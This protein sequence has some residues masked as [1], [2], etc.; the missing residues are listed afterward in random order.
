MAKGPPPPPVSLLIG[1]SA[2]D[3]RERSPILT[4]HAPLPRGGVALHGRRHRKSRVRRRAG[5]KREGSA[6]SANGKGEEGRFSQWQGAEGGA[7]VGGA[8]VAG[9]RRLREAAKVMG[10]PGL[11][12]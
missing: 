1:C 11:E 3:W 9:S 12:A 2:S 7:S 6:V 5:H 8:T 10:G 4:L